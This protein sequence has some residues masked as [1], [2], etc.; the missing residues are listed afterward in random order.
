MQTFIYIYPL[1]RILVKSKIV[2]FLL[3]KKLIVETFDIFGFP[4]T[5]YRCR[6]VSFELLADSIGGRERLKVKKK[7][8]NTERQA[9]RHN[10]SLAWQIS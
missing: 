1:F 6:S 4:P 7:N 9:E 5:F 8:G 3:K 2:E 10:V